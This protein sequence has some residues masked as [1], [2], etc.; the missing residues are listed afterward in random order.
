MG[1]LPVIRE[2]I[3]HK[4]FESRAKFTISVCNGKLSL[5]PC[6]NVLFDN[7]EGVSMISNLHLCVNRRTLGKAQGE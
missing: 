7:L 5:S 1:F 6:V 4:T 2:R 3:F